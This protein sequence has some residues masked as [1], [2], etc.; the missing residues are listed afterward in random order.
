M[1]TKRNLVCRIRLTTKLRVQMNK[2]AIFACATSM[3]LVA[4]CQGRYDKGNEGSKVS[5]DGRYQGL[6]NKVGD[7]VYFSYDDSTLSH[8]A[9]GILNRQAGYMK[10][11]KGKQFSLEGHC[12]IRGTKEYNIALGERRADSV[13]KYLLSLGVDKNQLI[14][15]SFGKEK[16]IDC[17]NNSDCAEAQ[18]RAKNRRVQT[19][20]K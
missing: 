1:L 20:A 17:H 7:T 5:H 19:V 3:L 4:G 2:I 9:Q 18:N 6:E 8:E 11:N 12:D 16:Q 14:T 10:S 15:I 13:K